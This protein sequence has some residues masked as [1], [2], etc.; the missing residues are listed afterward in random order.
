MGKSCR[1]YV[2]VEFEILDLIEPGLSKKIFEGYKLSSAIFVLDDAKS[3]HPVRIETC[4]SR[5]RVILRQL[6][7]AGL[8]D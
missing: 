2:E 8:C 7:N 1:G 4:G 5:A 6:E 3:E